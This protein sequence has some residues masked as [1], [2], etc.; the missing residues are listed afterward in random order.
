[1]NGFE[2]H[3]THPDFP[4]ALP[5]VLNNPQKCPYGLY[6]EQLSGTAFTCPRALNKR[7]WLYRIRPSVQHKPF[8]R[9]RGINDERFF[10]N[11]FGFIIL[12]LKIRV[13]FGVVFFDLIFSCF[14]AH[15][16]LV[17]LFPGNILKNPLE[18][19]F[20]NFF[21]FFLSL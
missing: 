17:D 20:H 14:R 15:I 21:L 5:P 9:F 18:F 8:E 1:L 4:D 13:V 7:T 6:A 16:G 12:N 3:S 2:Q 10:L 11:Y 19:I